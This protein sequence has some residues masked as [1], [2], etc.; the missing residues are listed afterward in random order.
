MRLD[1]IS[2]FDISR[3]AFNIKITNAKLCLSLVPGE[4]LWKYNF[5]FPYPLFTGRSAEKYSWRRELVPCLNDA[6][7]VPKKLF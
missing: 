4:H 1:D 3:N 7:Q 6:V 2:S 5:F